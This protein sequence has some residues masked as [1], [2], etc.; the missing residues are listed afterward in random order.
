MTTPNQTQKSIIKALANAPAAALR[1]L[2]RQ[3]P[4]ADEREQIKR[5]AAAL[6]I[7]LTTEDGK[8]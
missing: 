7:R 3:T 5:I 1:E 2:L 4:A 6:E 8:I